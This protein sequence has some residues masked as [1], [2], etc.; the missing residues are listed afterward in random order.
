MFLGGAFYSISMLPPVWQTI[1]LFNPVVYLISGFRWS[2][3]GTADVGVGVSIA[4]IARLHRRSASP[5][6]GGSSAPAG[7]SA[8]DGQSCRP[9]CVRRR[10]DDG[11]SKPGM[12]GR[13]LVPAV[14]GKGNGE[15]ARI[16]RRRQRHEATDLGRRARQ[17]CRQGRHE[18][19]ARRDLH[20]CEEA[21]HP[22][23]DP[24]VAS[25]AG[26]HRVDRRR[27]DAGDA[28]HDMVEREV[29]LHRERLAGGGMAGAHQRHEFV[30]EEP[31]PPDAGRGLVDQADHG[32]GAVALQR[33]EE[34]RAGRDHVEVERRRFPGEA[35]EQRRR[36]HGGV[37]I[38]HQKAHPARRRRRVE[39]RRPQ[40]LADAGQGAPRSSRQEFVGARAWHV[41]ARS[42]DQQR[43]AEQRA[44][45]PERPAGGRLAHAEAVGGA[46]H[47]P[48]FQQRLQRH[49]KVEIDATQIR[50][51]HE[52]YI[53]HALEAWKRA[54]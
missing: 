32:V 14:P 47:A 17:A 33:F 30:F 13:V 24:P 42:V 49:Q 2:F 9:D 5:S 34:R 38:G 25:H 28:D 53:D 29:A 11:A 4:A 51:V 10:V 22:H 19:R 43:V 44:Q 54:P 26:Q 37:E 40:H 18:I 52:H 1:T 27:T 36:E 45:P 6:S 3:F 48:L 50:F 8:P 35:H 41:A 23:P 12:A 46:G 16:D 39:R 15:P 31:A 21:R 20:G 7:A